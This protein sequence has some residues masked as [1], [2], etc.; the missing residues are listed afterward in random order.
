[1]SVKD[2]LFPDITKDKSIPNNL[3]EVLDTLVVKLEKIEDRLSVLV[4]EHTYE[5]DY[6]KL[7]VEP[8]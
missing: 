4:S 8:P 3:M 7:E 1:M 2:R 5:S 6:D